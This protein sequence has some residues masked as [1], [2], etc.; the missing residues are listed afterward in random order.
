MI[1][2]QCLC[3][4]IRFEI[5]N[6]AGDM[7][8]CH[9]SMC[10]KAHGSSFA[11]YLFLPPRTLSFTGGEEKIRAY[12]SSPGN[13]R[14]FCPVCGSTVPSV[15]EQFA[16]V[17]AGLLTE[18]CGTRPQAHIFAWSPAPWYEITDDLP[19]HDKFP[20]GLGFTNEITPAERSAS[21][22]G[23][24][25][26]SCLCNRVSFEVAGPALRMYNCHCSRCRL[27]RAAAHASNVFLAGDSFRW[28]SG[29]EAISGYKLPEAR[30][31]S[32]AFCSSCGSLVPRAPAGAPFVAIPAGVLDCD[33]GIR[34]GAHIYTAYKAPWFEI[35]DAIPQ[36]EES[37]PRA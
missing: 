33:P 15:T 18:D 4:E 28:L 8:H 2:G 26:G 29:E 6:A 12:E 1:H 7:S 3:G 32:T 22:A 25:T 31:F 17:P 23:M 36:F 9:C 35:T 21:A 11:T 24:L 13:Q 30:V 10:R 37:A 19:Q 14:H 16:F 27:S 20:P 5:E 34:P